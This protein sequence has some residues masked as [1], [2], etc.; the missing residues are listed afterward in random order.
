MWEKKKYS[1]A[2]W[3]FNPNMMLF[4]PKPELHLMRREMAWKVVFHRHDISLSVQS[5]PISSVFVSVWLLL[6]YLFYCFPTTDGVSMCFLSSRLAFPPSMFCSTPQCLFKETF[7]RSLPSHHHWGEMMSAH[8]QM[9]TDN[10]LL[11]CIWTAE[12]LKAVSGSFCFQDL[13][14]SG[15]SVSINLI[16][17]VWTKKRNV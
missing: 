15:L 8:A 5:T 3:Y 9:D 16:A 12:C 13:I 6:I 4:S 7:R 17:E 11:S 14:P 10:R 2:T 1:S